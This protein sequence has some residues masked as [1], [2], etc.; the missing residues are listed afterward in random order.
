MVKRMSIV[1]LL[2]STVGCA[3]CQEQ[4]QPVATN[5]LPIMGAT[6][7]AMAGPTEAIPTVGMSMGSIRIPVPRL[8]M[9]AVP[10]PQAGP[11]V[12]GI[13][14]MAGQATMSM[15]QQMMATQSMPVQQM[16]V[17]QYVAAQQ[18]YATQAV[19]TPATQSTQATNCTPNCNSCTTPACDGSMNSCQQELDSLCHEIQCL[20]SQIRVKTSNT[21]TTVPI[22][23][24]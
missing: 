8:R 20:Q 5:G 13:P 17:Q 10:R 1:C 24:K 11:Q 21:E 2:A 19:P 23:P 6:T 14:I 15:P 12:V 22:N 7:Q 18:S 9:Y 4:Q 3:S 16:P